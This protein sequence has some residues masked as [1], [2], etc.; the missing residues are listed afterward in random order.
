LSGRA[1]TLLLCGGLL[2]AGCG[3]PEAHTRA[4]ELLLKGMNT[5]RMLLTEGM[6]H[7]DVLVHSDGRE[8]ARGLDEVHAWLAWDSTLARQVAYDSLT[9]SHDTTWV[10]GA[11]LSGVDLAL[12]GFSQ[13]PLSEG[14]F[15]VHGWGGVREI[16]LSSPIVTAAGDPAAR[17]ADFLSW[18]T[19]EYPQRLARI[20]SQ[21]G[22]SYGVRTAA[23]WISLLTEWATGER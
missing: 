11:H 7:E 6:L 10:H 4:A 3:G 8:I 19:H 12:M 14:S 22:F 23:E 20:W 17:E 16:H 13:V 9:S 15:L 2:V 5:H 18:A 21:D 1:L